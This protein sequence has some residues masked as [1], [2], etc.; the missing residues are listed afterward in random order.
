MTIL[1]A[2]NPEVIGDGQAEYDISDC[3]HSHILP[4]SAEVLA[5]YSDGGQCALARNQFGK[6]VCYYW[7]VDAFRFYQEQPEKGNF[8]EIH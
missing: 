1:F 4:T 5:R 7:G 3:R 2:E 8:C 6:G